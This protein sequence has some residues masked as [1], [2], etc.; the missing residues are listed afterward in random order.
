M[1][2]ACPVVSYATVY[3]GTYTEL[4]G[5]QNITVTRGKHFFIDN[6]PA[7]SCQ[8][9]LIPANSYATP[10]AVGQY[11]DVRTSNNANAPAYFVGV[12]TDVERAYQMPYNAGTGAAPADRIFITATGGTGMLAQGSVVDYDIGSGVSTDVLEQIRQLC[13]LGGVGYQATTSTF[14]PI[15][16]QTAL[17]TAGI[18]DLINQLLRTGQMIMDDSDSFRQNPA[19]VQPSNVVINSMSPSAATPAVVFT[20]ATPSASDLKFTEINFLA[21]SQTLFKEVIV[22]AEE[23]TPQSTR[24]GATPANSLQYSTYNATTTDALSLSA[25]LANVLSNQTTA[26][27]YVVSSDTAANTAGSLMDLAF[28]NRYFSTQYSILG[29]A[30][31][32]VFR[33]STYYAVIQGLRASFYPDRGTM[34][35]FMSSSLGQPFTLDSSGFGILDTNRLG[36]P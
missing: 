5:V 3:N 31:E 16:N 28:V 34:S 20:D 10:L 15:R 21:S 30:A 35:V 25:Y 2:Y 13:I 24:I 1:T 4:T 19:V 9:E 6:I 8:I 36:F 27:P 18:L 33:G 12:I 14:V 7:S 23:L 22:E 29:R 26:A 11:I 17:I 32:I